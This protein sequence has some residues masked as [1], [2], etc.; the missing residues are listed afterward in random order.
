MSDK[1]STAATPAADS[2]PLSGVRIVTIAQNVPGPVAVARLVSEG[3]NAVKVEPP[4]GDPL[5]TMSRD[6]YDELHAGITVERLD[7][8]DPS[9]RARFGALLRDADLLVTSHRLSALGRL[10]LDPAALS[11]EAPTLRLLRI[12]GTVAEP[13]TPGHDLTYQAQ[14]GLVRTEMPPTLFAD[15][16]A[17]ERAVSAAL[18]LLREPAGSV[19]DVGIADSLDSLQQ[20]IR[21][22]LTTPTGLL[23]GGIPNYQVYPTKDG[24]IAVA[25][26][27]PHFE[28]RLYEVLEL[29]PGAELGSHF[30]AR[31]A[32]EWEGWARTHDLPVVAVI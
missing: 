8:K 10:G 27:E 18:L 32:V 30:L 23:G 9:G 11:R 13:D 20:P 7:L 29:S 2:R 22:G 4:A 6:W 1:Q 25:A 31:T 24:Y 16:V 14:A 3:A 5:A 19:R 28:R 12:V 15:L 21:R 26:L 17:A